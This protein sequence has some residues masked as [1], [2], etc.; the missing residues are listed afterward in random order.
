MNYQLIQNTRKVGTIMNSKKLNEY[1]MEHGIKKKTLAEALKMS[2]V[3]LSNRLNGSTSF[4]DYEL[5]AMLQFLRLTPEEFVN[6][7]N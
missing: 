3:T 4:K 1:L 2:P 5:S 6:F 7:F